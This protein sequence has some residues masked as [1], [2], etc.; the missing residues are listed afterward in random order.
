MERRLDLVARVAIDIRVHGAR[1]VSV[2][3][4]SGLFGR[5]VIFVAQDARMLVAD[6]VRFRIAVLAFAV[7]ARVD[8]LVRP[9]LAQPLIERVLVPVVVAWL[10]IR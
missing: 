9:F 8:Q 7:I 5:R 10:G 6:G 3:A 4:N 2:D 1:R